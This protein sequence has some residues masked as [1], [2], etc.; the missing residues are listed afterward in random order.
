MLFRSVG[1]AH[2]GGEVQHMAVQDE[3]LG[4]LLEAAAIQGGQGVLSAVDVAGGQ[5]GVHITQRHSGAG[6]AQDLKALR[7]NLVG[8]GTERLLDLD[9]LRRRR[10]GLP[11]REPRGH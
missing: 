9:C 8:G 10:R 7:L 4:H 11:N 3:V 1:G 2:Q 6:S 5:S